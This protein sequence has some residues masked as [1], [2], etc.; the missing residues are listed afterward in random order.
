M[1]AQITEDRSPMQWSIISAVLSDEIFVRNLEVILRPFGE[2]PVEAAKFFVKEMER[3]Y[4][5]VA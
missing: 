5:P 4:D 1:Y 3:E 2:D